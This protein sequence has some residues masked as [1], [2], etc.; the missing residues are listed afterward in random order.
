MSYAAIGNYF[1]KYGKIV[2]SII[3]MGSQDLINLRDPINPQDAV[4]KSYVDNLVTPPTQFSMVTFNLTD[5]NTTEIDTSLMGIKTIVIEPV[6]DTDGPIAIFSVVKNNEFIN[7]NVERL[8]SSAGINTLERLDLT[9]GAS[10]GILAYKTDN[11]YNGD[12]KATFIETTV[13][14]NINTITFNLV[15]TNP[16]FISGDLIGAKMIIVKTNIP[17]APYAKFTVC[18]N[19]QLINGNVEKLIESVGISSGT[20]LECE[21]S[22]NSGI[23]IYKTDTDFD[24]IY[25]ATIIP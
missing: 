16:T 24:G 8:I 17:N 19:S 4:T 3:D 2:K 12:Y 1:I 11:G 15:G 20:Q 25:S 14:T 22:I 7:A 10:S 13:P 9:W 6:T 21:W 5:T 23:S 18:K